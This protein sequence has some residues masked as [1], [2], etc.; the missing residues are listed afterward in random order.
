MALAAHRDLVIL[1][2]FV[3]TVPLLYQLC[4]CGVICWLYKLT[5]CKKLRK[6]LMYS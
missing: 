4:W 5:K 6:I 3:L 1:P 2:C